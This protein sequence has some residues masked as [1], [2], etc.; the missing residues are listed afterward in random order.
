MTLTQLSSLPSS[1]VCNPPVTRRFSIIKSSVASLETFLNRQLC[2]RWLRDARRHFYVKSNTCANHPTKLAIHIITNRSKVGRNPLLHNTK[3]YILPH[4]KY[5]CFKYGIDR[6]RIRIGIY[7]CCVMF[8]PNYHELIISIHRR[9]L[10]TIDVQFS[11][12]IS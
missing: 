5:G 7:I 3:M 6:L 9:I 12:C 11:W 4:H 10:G 1:Y 8:S 2:C